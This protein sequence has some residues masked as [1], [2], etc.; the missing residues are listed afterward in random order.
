MYFESG[1]HW[2]FDHVPS[3]LDTR[4]GIDEAGATDGDDTLTSLDG[5]GPL[6]SFSAIVYAQ[7]QTGVDY[8]DQLALA[9]ADP[10]TGVA[11]W[12]NDDDTMSSEPAY[13]VGVSA[14]SP[15][16]GPMLSV[17]WEFGGF[18]LDPLDPAASAADREAL[19]AAYISVLVPVGTELVR[20]NCNGDGAGV[21]IADAIY[22]LG[23]L[24]PGPGG[25]NPIA[26][27]DACDANDD[28]MLNIADAIALLASLFGSPAIPLPLPNSASGCGL[29]PTDADPLDCGT[30]PGGC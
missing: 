12:R 8:N 20:G 21:N 16:G 3:Q 14:E 23:F 25:P 22:L 27:R 18:A 26:C 13:I 11:V 1:D 24:F 2:G 7:D 10:A 5:Q 15:T 28:G 17:S 4:D 29:D 9:A 6:S 30:A 19:A